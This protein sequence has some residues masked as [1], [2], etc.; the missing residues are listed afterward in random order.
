I[1]LSSSGD[2]IPCS[3]FRAKTAPAV[4]IRTHQASSN[5]VAVGAR[6]PQAYQAPPAME[7]H[8]SWTR[9][10]HSFRAFN[11]DLAP[12]SNKQ[13]QRICAILCTYRPA[14][15]KATKSGEPHKCPAHPHRVGQKLI[16]GPTKPNRTRDVQLGK[17]DWGWKAVVYNL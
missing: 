11:P 10:P 5:L 9:E 6:L 16:N 3:G 2:A 1:A 8:R 4:G 12:K 14:P 15:E 7:Q 13:R 17:L